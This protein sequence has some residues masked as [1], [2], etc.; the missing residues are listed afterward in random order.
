[1][2]FYILFYSN[3]L[4]IWHCCPYIMHNNSI[5]QSIHFDRVEKSVRV[6]PSMKSH[7]LLY[8]NG[9]LSIIWYDFPNI[10]HI[11]S[12]MAA[13]QQFLKLIKFKFSGHIL[14]DHKCASVISLP[15]TA[16]FVLW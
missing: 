11:K 12:I 14:R 8:S 4:A 16:H 7:I 5:N 6:H 3:D 1:M 13:S 2:K 15:K 10:A 9:Q